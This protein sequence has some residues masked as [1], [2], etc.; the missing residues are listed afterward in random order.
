MRQ[1]ADAL[2]LSAE[3]AVGAFAEKSLS[4]LRMACGRMELWNREENQQKLLSQHQ[5][6]VS[7]PDR[8]SEQICISAVEMGILF[9]TKIVMFFFFSKKDACLT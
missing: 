4:V 2:M 9:L 7:L 5:L 3:S 6:A 1:Y 8:I